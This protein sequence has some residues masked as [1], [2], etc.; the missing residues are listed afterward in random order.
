[1]RHSVSVRMRQ[2]IGDLNPVPEDRFHRKPCGRDDVRQPLPFHIL[3]HDVRLA[4]GR[5]HFVNRADVRVIQL[6]RVLRLTP[7]PRLCVSI[8]ASGDLERY[9]TP[10]LH[11]AGGIHLAHA[12][13][14]E[15]RLAGLHAAHWRPIDEGSG[16]IV[17]RDQPL[18]F[19]P[20]LLVAT[21]GLHQKC[22]PV[23]R[24]PFDR[25]VKDVLYAA[26]LIRIHDGFVGAPLR[27]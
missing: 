11:V 14:A 26:P 4:I 22:R 10:Q 27:F 25:G 17:R 24:R 1:M 2:R 20:E 3:H 13:A 16:L 9:L 15:A 12:A 18:D 6:R 5:A 19:R 23:Q 8:D 21:A 7:Q